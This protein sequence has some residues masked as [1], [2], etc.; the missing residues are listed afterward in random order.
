MELRDVIYTP[1]ELYA[2]WK[3]VA[4][5]ISE[6]GMPL[7]V[8]LPNR[9]QPHMFAIYVWV[10]DNTQESSNYQIA[11]R[12]VLVDNSSFVD[13]SDENPI[14]PITANPEADYEWQVNLLPVELVWTSHF[15]NTWHVHT[16][17]LLP[18]RQEDNMSQPITGIFDQI[19]GD[20]PVR[21]TENIDGIIDFMY[22]YIKT[23]P[24]N[25]EET[26]FEFVSEPL[27]QKLVLSETSI[28]DG[29]T[30]Y[31]TIKAIDI[32]NNT[33]D[34]SITVFIDSSPPIIDEAYLVKDG[35]RYLFVHNSTDLSKMNMTF[36]AY[37]SHR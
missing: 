29:D 16:N 27:E 25:H 18:I 37:D 2:D 15:Y 22:K 33:F 17:L 32:M 21:G 4:S 5:N 30:L 13:T 3:I 35:Y 11:R 26:E 6:G 1:D 28:L 31:V 12:F 7:Q 8:T 10:L 34:D 14:V 36:L 9:G 24:R 23:S 19:I 20:L